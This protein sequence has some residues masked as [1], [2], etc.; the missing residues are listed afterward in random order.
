MVGPDPVFGPIRTLSEKRLGLI[1]DLLTEQN[2]LLANLVNLLS[3]NPV[4]R[5]IPV[6]RKKLK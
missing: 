3:P 5:V 6:D 2:Q 1:V 4:D